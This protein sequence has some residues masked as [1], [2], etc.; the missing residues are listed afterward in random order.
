MHLLILRRTHDYKRHGNTTL[1]AALNTATGS[2]IG[3]C[4]NRHRHQEFIS[5][6][7]LLN[8]GTLHRPFSQQESCHKTVPTLF[9]II[10]D[11]YGSPFKCLGL[12]IW[13]VG[14]GTCQIIDPWQ[15]ESE[16]G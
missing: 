7:N 8:M 9:S 11:D 16:H 14:G 15:P 3:K 2:V 12:K 1:F 6:L 5:F 4:Y 13:V 10:P